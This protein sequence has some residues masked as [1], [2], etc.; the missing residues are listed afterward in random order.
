QGPRLEAAG[1]DIGIV[2]GIVG[3][4][5]QVVRFAGRAD[6]A[7]TTP[8]AMRRDAAQ[9]MF[10]FAAAALAALPALASPRSVWNIG[11]VKVAPGAGNIVPSSAEMMI[12]Y[13]DTDEA[14]LDRMTAAILGLVDERNG[15]GGVGVTAEA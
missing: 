15:K 5:R 7:G 13:R 11:I 9:A 12:E 14:V 2:E 4:R 6:H 10:A 3:L 8:M 1:V